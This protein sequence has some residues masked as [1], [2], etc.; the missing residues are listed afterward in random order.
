LDF[1]FENTPS[2][3]PGKNEEETIDSKDVATPLFSVTSQVKQKKFLKKVFLKLLHKK[4][5]L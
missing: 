5:C 3:N 4:R 1:W 2:G